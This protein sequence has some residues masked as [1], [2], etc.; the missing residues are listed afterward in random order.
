MRK[1][2]FCPSPINP[3]S[4]ANDSEHARRRSKKAAPGRLRS[5]QRR[6]HCGGIIIFSTIFALAAPRNPRRQFFRRAGLGF[7]GRRMI[8]C[9]SP[10]RAF[11]PLM[12][13]YDDNQ[14]D[15]RDGKQR[16]G[17]GR[18]KS[19]RQP[20]RLRP[21]RFAL[22]ITCLLARLQCDG[23]LEPERGF[24]AG[25]VRR[26]L[27]TTRPAC[28][29]R[30]NCA[31]GF[32]ASHG[33]SSTILCAGKGAN[34]AIA[35]NRWK[36]FPNRIRPNLC[37]SNK[38]SATRK[39]AILWRSLEKI[40]EIYREPLVLFYREHQSIETVAANLDLTEDAVKQRLSRGRKLLQ[41]QVLAFVEGALARTN[42]GKVF[43]LGVLAAL[44]AMTFSVKAATIGAAAA[45][46]GATA[47]AAGAMGL[48]G[49]ILSP[50]LA[51]TGLYANYRMA[52][53]EAHSDEERGKIKFVFLTALVATLAFAA[54]MAVPLFF[55]VRKHDHS[56]ILFWSLLFSQVIVVYFLA[57]M[58]LVLMSL[59]ARRRHLA[60][61]LAN[62]YAGQF[63]TVRV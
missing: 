62:Q 29:S 28:A 52:R 58:A 27:E 51:I 13:R 38:P 19:F 17:I 26:R 48:F 56:S 41:E 54:A 3:A 16:C 14:N 22:S 5:F 34:Q 12:R 59:P 31:R 25:N 30:K 45:K 63:P 37:Q 11:L 53:D 32:A 18:R 10:L 36:K 44:P 47:K 46:G 33:I 40:P 55:A 24:G 49:A 50:L 4:R 57:L 2:F 35:P 39:P 8:N 43:T 61:I 42:P 7:C 21:D 9:L 15:A 60:E 1:P 23:Q 6:T 20:R